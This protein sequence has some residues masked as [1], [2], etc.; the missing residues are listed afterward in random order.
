MLPMGGSGGALQ[1]LTPVIINFICQVP[2]RSQTLAN[3]IGCKFTTIWSLAGVFA[4]LSEL[5]ISSV[6]SFS[7]RK[8]DHTM[9]YRNNR[10]KLVA[11]N[12]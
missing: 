12:A 10:R 11:V 4:H 3:A 8:S 5:L 7:V 9:V 2:R 6:W 1:R